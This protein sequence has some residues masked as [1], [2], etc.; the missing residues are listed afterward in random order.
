V[1]IWECQSEVP[2]HQ[3][4]LVSDR[5]SLKR[6]SQ[7]QQLLDVNSSSLGAATK[8]LVVRRSVT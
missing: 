5:A 1:W 8:H 4:Y 7:A 3:K 6:T 2:N